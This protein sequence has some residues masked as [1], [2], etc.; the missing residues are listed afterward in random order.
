[1]IKIIA[2][3][4]SNFSCKEQLKYISSELHSRGYYLFGI[5]SSS[6]KELNRDLQ[7]L[8]CKDY[9]KTPNTN[10]IITI[11]DYYFDI[12]K[13]AIEMGYSISQILLIDNEYNNI[14]AAQKCNIQICYLNS[15]NIESILECIQYYK[16]QNIGI[17]KKTLFQ[18][19][20]NIVIPIMGD[21]TRFLTSFYR[22]ERNL[23]TVMNKPFYTW[24]ASN[25]QIDANYIFIIREHL[26]R[27]HKI[28]IVLQSMFP[29][30]TIIKSE[31]KTEGNACSILLAEKYIN[32]DHPLI[33]VN[34]NQWLK[35]NVED[36]I[37]DFLLRETALLQIISFNPYGNNKFHYITTNDKFVQSI[38]LNKPISENA[39]TEVYFWRRGKDFI[40][41]THKMNS[42]N[43]RFIGEFCTT[44]VTNEVLDE[45]PMNSVIHV[46][47]ERY[48]IFNEAHCIEEFEKWFQSDEFNHQF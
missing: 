17:G 25:L 42:K 9:I 37:T 46:P 39:L 18:K 33:V 13:T 3:N 19:S 31:H 30:C 15:Y 41:Y 16:S 48:F 2:I 32:D 26:C 38:H 4:I 23:I 20:I 40:K 47:C 6:V 10:N 27:I 36:L 43:K 1:M 28:D 29:N 12:I 5:G 8:E 21:N 34:D 7:T 11:T 44:L 45:I 14:K 22:L 35:W 24:I